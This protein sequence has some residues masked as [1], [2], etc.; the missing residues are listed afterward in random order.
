[1]V[2]MRYII[3]SYAWIEYFI[4][5]KKGEILRKLLTEEKNQFLTAECCL[6]EINGWAL[7]NDK[8]FDILFKLIRAN[9]DIS[10]ITEHDWIEAGKERFEQRKKQKDFGLI[11]AVLLIKQKEIN[12]K[13]ISGDKHFKNLKNIVFLD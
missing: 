11:D 5:S 2:T 6:A 1:M 12:C 3:D 4:G 9:S 13:I 10:Q 8:D 7:R